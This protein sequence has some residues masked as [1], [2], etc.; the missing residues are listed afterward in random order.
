VGIITVETPNGPLRVEIAGEVPT[1]Q[2]KQAII[3]GITRM[4]QTGSP[5]VVTRASGTTK[6]DLATMSPEQIREYVRMRQQAGFDESGQ[7]MSAE[8]YASVYREEGVDYTQ[9][10]QDTGKFSRFGYGRM[11]TD[12]ERENYLRRSVGEGG[13]RQDALGRFVL[14]QKGRQ[15]LGMEAGPDLSIDE[16]GLSWGDFSEFLGA[17]ALPMAAGIGAGLMASGVGFLPGVAIAGAAAA[18]GKALDEGIEY[19]QGLQDQTFG[20]VMRDSAFEGVFATV[21]EGLGRGIS[22]AAGRL[23]KGPGGAAGEKSRAEL[24]DL[25]DRNF[26][27]TVSGGGGAEFRPILGRVQGM[28]E[29]MFPNKKAADLN[30]DTIIKEL[31]SLRVV[32]ET[33]LNDLSD[34]LK[35]DVERIYG[36]ADDNLVRAQRILDTTVEKN[37]G[38]V[39]ANLRTEGFV[40]KDIIGAVQLSKRLFDENMDSVFTKVDGVLK[41]QAIIPTA[42]I[43]EEL[44]SL[45]INSAADIASTKFA[46]MVAD[47]PK[48]ATVQEI[49]RIRTALSDATSNPGLVAD[50]N[51][52]A[53]GALKGSIT[54]ALNGAEV[55]LSRSVGMPVEAGKALGPEAFSASFDD[56]SKALGVL[57]RANGLYR[58]GM[59]R[60]DNAVTQ[61]IIAQARKP[62]GVNENFVFEQIIKKNNPEALRQLF[63]AVRGTRY[64]PGLELGDRTAAKLRVLNMPIEAARREAALLP[65]GSDAKRLLNQEIKRVEDMAAASAGAAGRGVERAEELR[66]NL[67]KMYLDDVVARSRSVNPSTGAYVIDPVKFVSNVQEKGRVFD[68]L[69]KG[70]KDQINDL[71]TVM[72]R[73]KDDIAPIVFEEITKRNPSLTRRLSLLR[74]TQAVKKDLSKDQLARLAESGDVDGLSKAVLQSSANADK[75]AKFLSADVMES[76]RDAAM[77]RILRQANI[78]TDVTNQAKMSEAFMDSFTSGSLGKTFQKVINSYGDKSL[79]NLF[80]AGTAKALNGLADDMIKVS[81]AAIRGKGGLVAAASAAA[82]TGFAVIFNPVA[83]L[84]AAVTPFVMS[85]ALR[86]PRVLRLLTASRNKNTLKQLVEGKFKSDD[87]IGQGLQAMNQ[88]VAQALSYGTAGAISQGEQETQAAQALAQRQSQETMQNEGVN[89]MLSDLGQVGQQAMQTVTSPIQ[90]LTQTPQ[91]PG[92]GAGAPVSSILVPN[93]TTRATFGG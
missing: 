33:A 75:A 71:I 28:Y 35:K 36:T 89:Q 10:L 46:R 48:Y 29:A 13:F 34:V 44:N 52:G 79:D 38:K 19:A 21:G 57:R 14:T 66:Q 25:L 2:E 30:A 72:S 37:L 59:A 92:P 51:I 49:A 60:F 32:D 78:S 6:P 31:R 69:F 20:D 3:A 63:M 70:E 62:G 22:A 77:S 8:E 86:D 58:K 54:S 27:P 64:I 50:V 87:V 56:I 53:L 81:D 91:A 73:A 47:L 76:V 15:N 26:R 85:K 24:R 11:D 41:G 16:E 39:Y 93:P 61:N 74:G 65:D 45:T 5:S 67:A 4:S 84:G 88:I 9:G 90:A 18:T 12:K 55:F 1:Q 40:P 42:G 17:N 23:I 83:V 43:K 68:E 7:Q 80:G 82:L